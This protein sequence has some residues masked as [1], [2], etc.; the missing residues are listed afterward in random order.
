L[1]FENNPTRRKGRPQLAIKAISFDFWHTLFTEQPGAFRL[2]QHR[3]RNLLAEL[4]P[5]HGSRIETDLT[6][7]CSIEAERHQRI[8]KEEHRTLP[9]AERVSAILNHLDVAVSEPMLAT[10]VAR[11]EEGILEHPP[12]LIAG[13]RE[14]LSNLAGSYRLG[15][16]SDVGFS[17]GR[18]LKKVLADNDLLDLFDSLVFSDEAGR[19]KPH[20]QVFERTARSLSA[21]PEEMVHVGDLERTDIMGARQAGYRAIR[22]T[23]IT[24]MEEG[25][26]TVAD[27]VTDDLTDIPRLVR[28]F[29]GGRE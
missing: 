17:P 2:Y 26:T 13:A 15:I 25:E 23:G 22:F 21:Q 4:F 19:A 14:A 5:Q 9:A 11:F 10:I 18:V 3:R 16:I 24:P 27:F 12:V 8:W 1:Q 20:I 7:A 28:M 6:R 29:E